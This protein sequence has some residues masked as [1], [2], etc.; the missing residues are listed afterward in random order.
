M[1]IAILS[2]IG[3]LV[4]LILGGEW[5]VRGAVS[6]SVRLG[7]PTLLTGLVV[8]GAATS[9][10]EMVASL[11]AALAGSPDLA[12]GNITGSN[13]ANS[14][15]ILGAAA[16]LTP[17]PLTGIGKRDAA[18]GIAAGL[19]LALLGYAGWASLWLGFVFLLLLGAYI[20]WRYMASRN[21]GDTSAPLH[22]EHE[23]EEDGPPLPLWKAIGFLSAGVAGLVIGGIYLVD[24]AIFIATAFGVSEAVIGLTIVAVGTSLPE[25][26]ASMIAAWRG[27]PALA[28]GNVL[29]SNIFNILLI[30]GATMLAAPSPITHELLDLEVPVMLASAVLLWVLLAY[31]R[32]IG[33]WLGVLLLAAFAANTLFAFTV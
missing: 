25:L 5:L 1:T 31:F 20:T 24:G 7:L 16:L 27:Q 17:I 11:S 4:V 23:A 30:G 18:A 13:I 26:A 21:R 29:G 10:P 8:V 9:M 6:L 28:L 2:L 3:G 22:D 19:Y 14:L 15:L 12:W 32:Q 33:R